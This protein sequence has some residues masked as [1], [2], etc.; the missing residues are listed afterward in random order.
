[1]E[2]QPTQIIDGRW[3]VVRTLATSTMAELLLVR[4]AAD[5]SQRLSPQ[6]R[7]THKNEN[8]RVLKKIHPALAG[9]SSIAAA[10]ALESAIAM[11]LQHPN[12]VAVVAIGKDDAGAPYFVMEWLDGV[13]LKTLLRWLIGQ[14]A[15]M[16]PAQAL[17]I[18]ARIARALSHAHALTDDQGSAP[19]GVVH[20]DV[21]PHN[22]FMTREGAVKLLDFGVAK[23]RMMAT[24]S[25]LVVGKPA[26]MAPEQ[27]D[28]LRVDA[29]T[30]LFALGV[31]LWE[32]L[33]G[34]QLWH[35]DGRTFDEIALHVRQGSAMPPSSHAAGVSKELDRFVLS[36]L[37]KFPTGRPANAA[38]ATSTLDRL[39]TEHGSKHAD[40]EI[41][42]L[43]KR[44]C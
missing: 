37:S 27:I 23:T 26:Y 24:R 17:A 35:A 4:D 41:A 43:V 12:I 32:M 6:A 20:R 13:D 9:D 15:Q 44:C 22:I 1:V 36:L 40:F 28:G 10:F 39:A 16:H 34:R 14:R 31:V 5:G 21:S 25:G 2:A 33:T 30:D 29:R 11:R 3:S 18:G 8:L 7:P 42:H 38:V 19:L